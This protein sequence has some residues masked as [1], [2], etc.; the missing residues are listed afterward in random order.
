MSLLMKDELEQLL[1][2]SPSLIDGFNIAVLNTPA[3]P[4]KGASVYL[5]VGQIFLPG[6]SPDD[7]GSANKPVSDISLLPGHTAVLRTAERILIPSNVAG[8]AF[9]PSRN[10]SLAGLL[11]TNPGHVDPGYKGHLHLT[12]INMGSSPFNITRGQQ[13]MRLLLFSLSQAV[14]TV[15]F[16]QPSIIDEELL[17]RLSKDFLDIDSRVTAAARKA[18]EEADLRIKRWQVL[19]PLFG[20]IVTALAGVFALYY[21]GTAELRA[22]IARIEGKLSVIVTFSDIKNLEERLR[23]LE[24]LGG[25]PPNRSG[26]DVPQSPSPQQSVPR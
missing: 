6:R 17:A 9:P 3:S 4:V 10:I 1:R 19:G 11:T 18:V 25:M 20:G 23:K 15:D 24:T 8:I 7:L 16:H 5:T 2:A 22:Q 21:S 12:V 26:S 13:I 14:K